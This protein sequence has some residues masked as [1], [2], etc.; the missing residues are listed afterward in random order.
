MFNY[1]MILIL[2]VKHTYTTYIHTYTHM[3]AST[4]AQTY[5]HDFRSD[6]M[7]PT[8]IPKLFLKRCEYLHLILKRVLLILNYVTVRFSSH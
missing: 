1:K 2:S 7:M 3:N 5:L 8:H 4:H 6:K